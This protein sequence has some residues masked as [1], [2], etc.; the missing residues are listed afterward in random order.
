MTAGTSTTAAS[1]ASAYQADATREARRTDAQPG[2]PP[3]RRRRG[4]TRPPPAVRSPRARL[5]SAPGPP[6]GCGP[7]RP[8]TRHQEPLGAEPR[9]QARER[10]HDRDLDKRPP[11]PRP[12]RAP[13]RAV[14][15][16]RAGVQNIVPH[17][18][19]GAAAKR[20]SAR[21]SAPAVPSTTRPTRARSENRNVPR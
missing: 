7:R 13:G 19:A 15:A 10:P 17:Q 18:G 6:A 1:S 11:P 5:R 16:D 2:A 8:R 20:A 3:R 4:R 12:V 9:G 21:R 14:N